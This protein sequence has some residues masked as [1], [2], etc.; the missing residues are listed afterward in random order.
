MDTEAEAVAIKR[1]IESGTDFA[2]AAQSNS[3]DG[4][5]Q[6]GGQLGCFDDSQFVEPFATVA[7]TQPIGVVSDPV[8][9]EFGYHLILTTDEPP[10]G[11]LDEAAFTVF[12]GRAS[13][14]K[15]TKVSVA[16]RY[17]SWDRRNLT[18]APPPS[19]GTAPTTQP[20]IPTG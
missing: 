2:A 15:V 20:A 13:D 1:A 4:S 7:A 17:G 11:A 10:P 14:P 9:T 6:D 16:D 5:A 18:V 19:P 8:Q 3:L 12:R